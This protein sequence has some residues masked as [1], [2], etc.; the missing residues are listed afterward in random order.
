VTP[1]AVRY[2][3]AEIAIY[4]RRRDDGAEEWGAEIR[5]PAAL[6]GGCYHMHDR[7]AAS[8][9]AMLAAHT[10]VDRFLHRWGPQ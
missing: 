3:G 6:G 5:W 9:D 10:W 2:H 4:A 8:S 7:Q 1:G